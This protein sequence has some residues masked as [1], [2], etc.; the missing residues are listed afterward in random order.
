MFSTAS[1][2]MRGAGRT[3]ALG[4]HGFAVLFFHFQRDMWDHPHILLAILSMFIEK[5]EISDLL[6]ILPSLSN[7]E[8]LP[9][10]LLLFDICQIII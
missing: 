7:E 2:V 9:I 10:S 8:L 6:F 1:R 5:S 4:R 3:P